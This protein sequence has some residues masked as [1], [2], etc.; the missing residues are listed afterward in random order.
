MESSPGAALERTPKSANHLNENPFSGFMAIFDRMLRENESIFKNENA[1]DYSFLPKV[2]PFREKEQRDVAEC[3]KPL[4]AGRMGRNVLV[5]GPPG[6]GKT[7][8]V[9]HL[10]KELEESDE[11]SDAVSLVFINCWQKN[12]TFKVLLELADQLEYPFVQNKSSEELWQG[13]KRKG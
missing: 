12:T 10:L 5:H 11:Y 9:R 2:I 4:L 1:L 13:G 7:A 3:I 8:A 6:V